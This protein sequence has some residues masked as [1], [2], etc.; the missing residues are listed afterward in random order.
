MRIVLDMLYG[1]T[2]L[3]VG[4]PEMALFVAA[5][6]IAFLAVSVVY[7]RGLRHASQGGLVLAAYSW[8]A[9]GLFEASL[10]GTGANIRVDLLVTWPALVVLSVLVTLWGIADLTVPPPPP[11]P[12]TE[13]PQG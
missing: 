5:G 6:F 2:R 11:A 7:S 9:F 1:P 13:D 10:V 3:F 4:H 12:P 8:V